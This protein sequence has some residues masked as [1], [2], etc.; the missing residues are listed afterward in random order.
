M[1]IRKTTVLFCLF[2][3][4]F[5]SIAQTQY[6]PKSPSP[7]QVL[8]DLENEK[9]E[10]ISKKLDSLTT[11]TVPK[12]AILIKHKGFYA[13]YSSTH[14]QPYW[15]SHIVPKDV[16]YGS[17][18]RN[19]G[20]ILDSLYLN[21]ADST[22]FWGSGYDRGHLAPA[23]DFRWNKEAMR[24]SFYYTNIATQ[25]KDFNRGA[26]AKLE[27]Q[28]R[29]FAIDADEIYVV[30][31]VVLNQKLAQIPQGTYSVSI[32]KYFYK[33]LYDLKQPKAIAFLMPNKN[34]VYDIDK[35]IVSVDSIESLTELDFLP[36][37]ED[38]IESKIEKEKDI[39][40]WNPNH[41]K[42]TETLNKKDYGKGKLNA[43]QAQENIGKYCTI[44]GKVA[45]TKFVENNKTNPTYLNIDKAFPNQIFTVLI[46]QEIRSFLGY[47]PENTLQDKEI[48]IFGKV[49]QYKGVPQI[50]L[51]K[52]EDLKIIE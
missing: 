19:D 44:C 1:S 2:V 52:K 37:L 24:E 3:L 6:K 23:A 50:T 5:I 33:I 13:A 30:T 42:Y 17:Y 40:A 18:T 28:V 14:K 15:V 11:H 31:G 49:T 16:L 26:W 48:C 27:T 22:D 36:I 9:L 7:F 12:D 51:N 38:K 46:P 43:Y 35:Y 10:Y 41:Q 4:H 39:Y 25:N 32:P 45:S 29:E 21:T 20:F 47:K 34:I 8:Y